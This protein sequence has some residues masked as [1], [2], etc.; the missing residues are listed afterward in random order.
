MDA[1]D[2]AFVDHI[3]CTDSFAI[4]MYQLVHERSLAAWQHRM[5]DAAWAIAWEREGV[6]N[7]LAAW[8]P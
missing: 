5:I 6:V 7:A 3:M 2:R 8:A 1:E 4:F